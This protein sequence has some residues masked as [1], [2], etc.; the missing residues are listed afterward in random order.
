MTGDQ[1]DETGFYE[2]E[3]ELEFPYG[4]FET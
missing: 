4:Y 1:D 3:L 2:Y